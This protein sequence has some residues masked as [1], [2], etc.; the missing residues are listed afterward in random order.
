MRGSK[1]FLL[2]FV[3]LPALANAFC[4]SITAPVPA[5][6]QP[7]GSD[8]YPAGTTGSMQYWR[9]RC[10]GWSLQ[11]A[12]SSKIDITAA[13]RMIAEAFGAW[14]GASCGGTQK[15]SIAFVNNGVSACSTVGFSQGAA[16]QHV[17]AFRDATWPYPGQANS[18][19]ALT[20]VTFRNRTGEI[21]D[22]DMEINTAEVKIST[23]DKPAA[24][25][26]DFQSIITHEAGHFLGL[27]HAVSN[28]STMYALYSAGSTSIRVLAADDMAAVCEIYR[29]DGQRA[30][31]P[32]A[33]TSQLVAGGVCDGEPSG[34]FSSACTIS[35]GSTEDAATASAPNTRRCSYAPARSS[36]SSSTWY[37]AAI[38][39]TCVLA[40]RRRNLP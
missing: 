2:A 17:I 12:P 31:S 36:N 32:A 23:T 4:R 27:A 35:G 21:V 20:T 18:T 7:S 33:A 8:C 40:R 5:S 24:N 34:G 19:L 9:N 14:S 28:A 3:A 13:T 10:V 25:D 6:S 30:V 15:P 1:A 38:A 37:F 26:Y 39:V 22:A 16:N 29:P 11:S